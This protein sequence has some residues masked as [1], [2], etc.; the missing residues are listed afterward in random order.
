MHMNN[1]ESVMY[2]VVMSMLLLEWTVVSH[3]FT[4]IHECDDDDDDSVICDMCAWSA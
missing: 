4:L 3:V 2:R 1:N